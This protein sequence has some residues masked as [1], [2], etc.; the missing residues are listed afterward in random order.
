MATA[1][2][3][4]GLAVEGV[5]VEDIA[6]T[7]KTMPEFPQMWNAMLGQRAEAPAGGSL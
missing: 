6:T 5:E 7:S 2:A 3:I 4:L 1:G